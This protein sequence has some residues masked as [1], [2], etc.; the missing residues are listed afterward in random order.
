MYKQLLT[1]L[2]TFLF[3]A[4]QAGLEAKEKEDDKR[5]HDRSNK[6]KGFAHG[7]KAQLVLLNQAIAD[8]SAKIAFLEQRVGGLPG[9]LAATLTALRLDID[10]NSNN[11]SQ[12]LD[13]IMDIPKFDI[14]AIKLEITSIIGR[15]DALGSSVPVEPDL[16]FSG[17]FIQDGN[18][19]RFGL[20]FD[21]ANFK[22]N[23][24]GSFSSI[25]IRNS[26]DG[27]TTIAGSVVCDTPT[28][29]D[30]IVSELNTHVPVPGPSLGSAG[31]IMSFTCPEPTLSENVRWNIGE[32]TGEVELNA[33]RYPDSTSAAVCGTGQGAVVRPLLPS[34][35]W[36]GV[37]TDFGGSGGTS[38]A[39]SQ[40]L[41]VILLR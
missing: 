9:D 31:S 10:T 20:K 17:N 13:D 34:K 2:L 8:I 26:F 3:L 18:Q 12:A 4:P 41:E 30:Q 25:Q 28:I 23:A 37:G 22:N 32:C 16:V 1:I 7:T 36:G 14:A 35:S 29:V 27:G 33:Q 5:H 38:G 39:P 21:W 6:T 24:T 19:A 15:L 11:V 40:T